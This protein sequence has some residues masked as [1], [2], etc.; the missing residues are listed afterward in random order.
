M[1]CYTVTREYDIPFEYTVPT[2]TAVT[3]PTVT[4]TYTDYDRFIPTTGV[5][6]ECD[7]YATCPATYTTYDTMLPTVTS[8]ICES[9]II[10]PYEID[11]TVS[12]PVRDVVYTLGPILT[13]VS[14]SLEDTTL[15]ETDLLPVQR[16]KLGLIDEQLRQI[17][18]KTEVLRQHAQAP[19][20]SHG[21]KRLYKQAL[22]DHKKISASRNKICRSL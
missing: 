5:Y 12:K 18:M 7:S 17:E 1:A 19:G 20:A 11:A 8:D 13:E 3:I 22:K 6:T 10:Y 9:T 4:E 16:Q 15:W 2:V 14:G 21:D